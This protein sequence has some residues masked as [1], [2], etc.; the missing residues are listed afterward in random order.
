MSKH[1]MAAVQPT[2]GAPSKTV[3]RLVRVLESPAVQYDLWIAIGNI[4]TIRIRNEQQLWCRTDPH[5]A[6]ADFDRAGQI[7]AFEKDLA[8]FETTVCIG[9]FKDDHA[10]AAFALG[11]FLWIGMAFDYPNSSRRVKTHRDRLRQL[12]FRSDQV[13]VKAIVD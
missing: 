11:G 13:D 2:V 1:A 8:G 5:A 6:K 7:Q 4:V 3:Q 10:I 12:G 9:V